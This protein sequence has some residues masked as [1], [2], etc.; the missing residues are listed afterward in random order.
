MMK[1]TGFTCNRC[2]A[3]MEAGST[4]KHLLEHLA[5]EGITVRMGDRDNGVCLVVGGYI[6]EVTAG[7]AN[8]EEAAIGSVTVD[9]VDVTPLAERG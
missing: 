5:Q 8:Y 9:G 7:L 3:S 2:G 4:G 6:V 1:A